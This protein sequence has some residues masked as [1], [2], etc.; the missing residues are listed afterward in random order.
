M[1]EPKLNKYNIADILDIAPP[2]ARNRLGDRD[3]LKSQRQHIET[4]LDQYRKEPEQIWET[5]LKEALRSYAL[6]GFNV[7]AYV[8][9]YNITRENE[10]RKKSTD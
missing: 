9:E 5:M 7:T 4:I 6:E 3:L 10:Q 1:D 2:V 8:N